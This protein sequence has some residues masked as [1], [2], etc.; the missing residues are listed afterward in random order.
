MLLLPVPLLKTQNTTNPE[1][2]KP[3]GV[4]RLPMLGGRPRTG[5]T[6]SKLSMRLGAAKAG[7]G[8]S[9]GK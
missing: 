1:P 5:T 6:K 4:P 9:L 3:L 2:T 7:M 8:L